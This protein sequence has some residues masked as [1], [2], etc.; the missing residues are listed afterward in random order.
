MT[1]QFDDFGLSAFTFVHEADSGRMDDFRYAPTH[2]H[3]ELEIHYVEAGAVTIDWTDREERM[4]EGDVLAFW[5]GLPHR[6]VD[7]EP[8]TTV[9]HVAQVPIVNVLTWVAS[10]EVLNR[11]LGG[12][13]LR[14]AQSGDDAMAD[15][16]A[17]TRWKTDLAAGDPRLRTAAEVEIQARLLRLMHQT[18]TSDRTTRHQP[19]AAT[20]EL[21]A[22]AITYI[23]RHFV[24]PITVEHVARAVDRHHDHLMASFRQVCGLTLWEY[25][26]R[27]RL[28]EA[29]RLLAATDL[30]ILAVCHRSGFSSTSRLYEAF[31]RYH[32][33]TPAV[34]RKRAGGP[35]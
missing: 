20:R 17:F 10:A 11:L 30:P 9:Y 7:P 4:R 16:L 33:M 15:R 2:T 28:S 18:A 13:I 19:G 21:V 14:R 1:T 23:T 24:E 29:Q 3:L 31:H 6:D 34:Y 12:E 25:V 35:A 27:L 8:P 32:G 26:T 22:R 5:G